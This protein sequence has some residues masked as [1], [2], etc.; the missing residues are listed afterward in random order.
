M[1]DIRHIK[2]IGQIADVIKLHKKGHEVS[3]HKVESLGHWAWS[4]FID[5]KKTEK[6]KVITVR[7]YN[8]CLLT[9]TVNVIKGYNSENGWWGS[10]VHKDSTRIDIDDQGYLK[11]QHFI[12]TRCTCK[13][14]RQVNNWKVSDYIYKPSN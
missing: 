2:H 9:S 10:K 13:E 6:R 8:D 14:I 1:I 7:L 4:V 5:N 3:L 11:F 12:D